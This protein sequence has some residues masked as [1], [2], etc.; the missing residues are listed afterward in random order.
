MYTMHICL[1]ADCVMHALLT[2]LY[3]CCLHCSMDL[4]TQ[5]KAKKTL[6]AAAGIFCINVT[7]EVFNINFNHMTMV[8]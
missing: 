8:T 4:W 2:V 3:L 1:S 7:E 6:S 5:M